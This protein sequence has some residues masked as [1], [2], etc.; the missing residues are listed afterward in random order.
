MT[1]GTVFG[2]GVGPGDPE[3]ITLK[4]LKRLR[5]A[6]AIAYPVQRGASVARAIVASYLEPGQDEIPIDAPMTGGD[7]AAPGYDAAAETISAYLERGEDVA[8]LCE[9]DPLFYG[10]FIYL[11]SR[12][13]GRG[14]RIEVV[15]GVS[16]L[17]AC[18]AA[19]PLPLVGRDERLA[20][21]P[22]VLPDERLREGLAFADS[23][24]LV[25]VGRH[26][27]RLK[28]LIESL[29][30]AA[31]AHYVERASQAG[32]RVLPLA[33]VDPASATYFAIILVLKETAPWR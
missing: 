12:L 6:R 18:A 21:M 16:S 2:L 11:L 13:A 31:N 25:K 3:L 22:A 10:S 27:A 32:Q 28:A 1:T 23:I 20:V 9:G 14:H 7:S 24:A 26:F 4:A 29:G 19:L 17:T 5:A 8:V 15:P 30:L 33:E